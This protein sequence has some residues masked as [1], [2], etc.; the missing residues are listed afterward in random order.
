MCPI[1]VAALQLHNHWILCQLLILIFFRQNRNAPKETRVLW[2]IS[3]LL[4]L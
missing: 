3:G 1:V 2:C 4:K